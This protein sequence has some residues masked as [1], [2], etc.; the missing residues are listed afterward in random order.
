[1]KTKW[2][3]TLTIGLIILLFF[4][5]VS[6]ETTSEPEIQ[7]NLEAAEAYL[8]AQ[9]RRHGFKG[10]AAAI[11][12]G[13]EIIYLSGFGSAGGGQPIAPQTPFFIGSVSKSFTALAVMQLVDQGLVDLD[14]PVQTYLPWFTTLDHASSS[15]ITVR[16]LLN[17]TS[18]LSNSSFRRPRITAETTLEESVRHLS[19]A[20]LTAE[21]GTQ[22]NYFNPNYNVL[23]QVVE[24][25]SGMS[26]NRYLVENIFEPLEM[27]HS[28][29][30]RASAENAGLA[31]GY[32]FFFGMT[33]PRQQPFYPAEIPAGFI[34]SSA[35]DMAHYMI[36]Q[37][38]DGSFNQK[39][40]LSPAAVA[41]MH[42]APADVPGDY[43]MGW[44]VQESNGLKTIR[45]NGAV[46]TFY[47]DVILLPEHALGITLLL[48]QNAML[49]QLTTYNSLAD[50]LIDTL[51]EQQPA[52]GGLS[53]RLIYVLL[54]AL[55]IY[56]LVR[57]V[58]LIIKLAQ[59]WE[60]DLTQSKFKGVMGIFFQ[61]L[62]LPTLF[63]LIIVMMIAAAGINAARVTFLYQI[64]DLTL[65]LVLSSILSIIEALIKFRWWRVH[66]T[67]DSAMG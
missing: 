2:L 53:L 4:T 52:R 12:Q 25:V 23:A 17:Q 21:P 5:G 7:P 40:I 56:D 15:Q 58:L 60:A 32:S 10:M 49:P 24:A 13:D 48:N 37:V 63:I 6:A 22:F 51:L 59:G 1:M 14:S 66:K 27:E 11:T 28:F 50:G 35:E 30:D 46:E 62:L 39:A 47:A 8:E 33:I 9:M 61:H 45:H 20:Q 31:T 41:V 64:L 67:A 16:H 54:S 55:V 29:V 38:N 36:A 34:I 43:A 57:H 44:I 18:G 3:P 19:Q 26:F 65:W 42:A